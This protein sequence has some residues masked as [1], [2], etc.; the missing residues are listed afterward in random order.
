[1]NATITKNNLEIFY[2]KL[3]GNSKLNEEWLT[4]KAFLKDGIK[5]IDVCL[6]N[7]DQLNKVIAVNLNKDLQTAIETKQV[8]LK[9]LS[10][11]RENKEL[12]QL[13]KEME[14]KIDKVLQGV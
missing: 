7:M 11:E 5:M 1:M 4:Y 10:L 2:N 6:D 9:L 3:E 14:A 12:K 13:N 8:N